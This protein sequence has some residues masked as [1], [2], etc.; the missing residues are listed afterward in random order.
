MDFIDLVNLTGECGVWYVV[1]GVWSA[2]HVLCGVKLTVSDY[3]HHSHLSTP[4]RARLGRPGL[5]IQIFLNA[6]LG[7]V[8]SQSNVT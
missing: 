2:H 6:W 1:C 7:R 3:C 5:P 8:W 4:A